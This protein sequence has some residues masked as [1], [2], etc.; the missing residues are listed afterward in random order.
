MKKILI[1]AFVFLAKSAFAQKD[2]VGLNVP[3]VNNT[4]I[5]ERVFDAPNTSETLLYSNAGLGWQK[6][7]RM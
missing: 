5:Y 3:Y 7:I 2:T 1:I 6:P 4:V